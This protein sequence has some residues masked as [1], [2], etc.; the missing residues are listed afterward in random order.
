MDAP[1]AEQSFSHYPSH[2]TPVAVRLAVTPEHPCSYFPD[3]LART[4]AF[5][6]PSIPGE[7]YHGFMD[8]GFR[9]SGR[10][11]Y[12]PICGGCRDCIPIR[13]PVATFLPDKTQRRCWRKN[14]DLVVSIDPP[15]PTEEKHALY[16]KYRRHWHAAV[17]DGD[18]QGFKSFL[19]DSPVETMEVCYRDA[20]GNLVGV[21][22]CDVCAESLSSVYFYF[23]PDQAKRNLGT[24]SAMWEIDWARRKSIPHYYLG[25][26]V[27][28]CGAM[29]YKANFRPFEL[30]GTDGVWRAG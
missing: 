15:E 17:E 27:K 28:G 13:V 2:P 4:R 7:L 21:G 20:A 9:R 10:V 23:D 24:F 30:L 29:E 8:A 26:W 16:E 18:W 14:Q 19:Y 6:A 25:Y 12:Q 1:E 22:I 5:W 11:I 3:R